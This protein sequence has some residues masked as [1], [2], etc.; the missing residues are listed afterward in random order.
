MPKPTYRE[1]LIWRCFRGLES[2]L[3]LYFISFWSNLKMICSVQEDMYS[4]YVSIISSY[5]EFKPRRLG[6][7][8]GPG[9]NYAFMD[10]KGWH[11][12]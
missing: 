11:Y 10:T 1:H 8:K 9:T 12:T 3:Y 6:H 5:N 4:L 2:T 7:D